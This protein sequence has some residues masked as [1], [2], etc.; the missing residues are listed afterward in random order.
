[1][2]NELLISKSAISIIRG[3]LYIKESIKNKKCDVNIETINYLVEEATKI[4][5]KIPIE[6]TKYLRLCE[7]DEIKV[8]IL[9]L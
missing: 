2:L 8:K 7:I 4:G 1:M 5:I 9:K 3:L 6:I